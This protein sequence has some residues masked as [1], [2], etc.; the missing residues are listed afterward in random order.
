MDTPNS[1][2][3]TAPE[4][5]PTN[6]PIKGKISVIDA[7]GPALNHMVKVLFKPFNIVK[8]LKFG[9]VAFLVALG[10][11]GGGVFNGNLPIDSKEFPT[12]KIQPAIEWVT[13]HITLFIILIVAA[14]LVISIIWMVVI[15][16]SSRFTFVY[17]DGVVK[18]DMQIKRAYKEN[19][20]SGWSY[21]LWRMV[22][23]PTVLTV[24]LLLLALA[25]LGIYCLVTA[26]G[27]GALA[28][29]LIILGVLVLIALIIFA[30]VV[31]LFI[32]DFVVPIMYLKKLR[33][34][35]AGKVFWGL[36]KFNK[37]QFFLYVLFKILLGMAS[38]IVII[39]P[40]CCFAVVCI[41]FVLLMV[42]LV[43]LAFKL[44]I[45]WVAVVLAALV[46]WV[47]ISILWNTIVAPVTVF[48]RTYP[49]VF[50]EGFGKEFASI[51]P[52]P[53]QV[54]ARGEYVS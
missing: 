50:L 12:Y 19:K 30:V 1:A 27:F 36:L 48:F 9:L 42:G 13:A 21:F 7:I 41:P 31:N 52:Q 39:L 45:I 8:W 38:A 17:L 35:K 34:V 29:I 37:T 2:G 40:C 22:F 16:F 23:G 4:P 28:I 26:Y 51:T 11:G 5:M 44:S 47:I 33:I 46:A 20:L 53:T 14:V 6:V 24:I 10:S 43:A 15:Y 25:G 49:L 3:L 32:D 54:P 18:N